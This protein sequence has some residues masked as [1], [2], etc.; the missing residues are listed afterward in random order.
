MN[1]RIL[2]TD[3]DGTLL[4]DNKNITPGNQQAIDEALS[5]GHKIVLSTGRPLASAKI[6]AARLGLTREGCY[7]ITY[8]GG[9]IYDLYRQETLFGR[10]IPKDLV[11]ELFH[12]AS[13]RSLH[14]HTYTDTHILSCHDTEELR[15]YS[16]ST[17][18]P[19][20]IAEPSLPE[21]TSEPYKVLA[22]DYRSMAP[23]LAYQ[24]DIL[25]KY[26]DLLDSFFSSDCF[27]EIVPKNI[28]K[29]AS[30][31]WLCRHL[32]IPLEHSVAAG[33]AQNDISML[34]AAHIGAV[35]CNAFP[36]ISEHGNYITRADNNHDGVAEIIRRFIL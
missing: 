28:N 3:L 22:I 6:Q 32:G 12:A 34:E 7:A 36:G 33:D 1:T 14:I 16:A 13:A 8:N 19:Y 11:L 27:L 29:G 20:C 9:L 25:Q 5:L 23:L 21:L 31:R 17:L 30:V 24:Q 10:T 2:F 26:S 15:E 35:M 18:L 4:D